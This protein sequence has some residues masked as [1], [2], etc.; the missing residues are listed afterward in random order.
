MRLVVGRRPRQRS[1]HNGSPASRIRGIR[2]PTEGRVSRFSCPKIA[3]GG[4]P[5]NFSKLSEI[6]G[7]EVFR[8]DIWQK[9]YRNGR[10]VSRNGDLL[11]GDSRALKARTSG[12]FDV[13]TEWASRDSVRSL[14][15]REEPPPQSI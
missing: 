10:T 15:R 8:V 13:A 7:H 3:G 9:C 12:D 6:K 2:A 5:H 11:R 1:E 14:L 4:R